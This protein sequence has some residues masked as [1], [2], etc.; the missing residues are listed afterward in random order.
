[1]GSQNRSKSVDAVLVQDLR[2]ANRVLGEIAHL[3]RSLDAIEMDKQESIARIKRSSE[4]FAA[5]RRA[6]LEA[7]VAGLS[8]FAFEN[9]AILFGKKRGVELTYGAVGFRGARALR[10]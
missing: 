10:P 5:P 4:T 1:M 9:K 3:Q 8:M 6:R 2:D 7:L